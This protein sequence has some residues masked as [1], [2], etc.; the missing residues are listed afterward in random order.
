LFRE[1]AKIPILNDT[2]YL[3]RESLLTP[4]I[5]DRLAAF[6]FGQMQGIHPSPETMIRGLQFAPPWLLQVSTEAL[7]LSVRARKRLVAVEAE[8]VSDI[9]Q[10]GPDGLVKINGLGQKSLVD[11]AQAIFEAFEAGSSYC[12]KRKFERR[13]GVQNTSGKGLRISREPKEPTPGVAKAN[14][15]D[16]PKSF[17]ETLQTSFSLLDDRSASVL[18]Q[19]MGVGGSRKTLEEIASAYSLTRVRVRPLEAKAVKRIVS[20]MPLWTSRFQLGLEE[21][22]E[23]RPTPLPLV[24]LSVLDPWFIGSDKMQKYFG[25][26]LEHFIK[27]SDLNLLHIEGHAY[28][29]KLRQDEWE[30]AERSAKVLLA[31][32]SKQRSSP[33]E[34][35]VKVVID[36]QLNGRGEE[37]RP[38][39]WEI[40]TRQAYF[41]QGS[42]GD[43]VLVS[44]GAGAEAVVEAVLAESANPLHYSEIAK[45]CAKKGRAI[46]MRHVLNA[47]ANVGFLL[48]RGI[49]GLAKHIDFSQAEQDRILEE[50]E[51]MLSE[52][53]GRQWHAAEICDELEA[54]GLDFQGRLSEYHLNAIL[55][56][57]KVLA[58]LK[59]MVWAANT[60]DALGTSDRKNIWQAIV[61]LLRAHGSPMATSDIRECIS[62][63]RGLG[64]HF[65]IHQS[66]PLIRV[67]ENRWGILWRDV[68]IPESEAEDIVDELIS[69]LERR[70][71]GLH[72]TEIVPSLKGTNG[73]LSELDPILLVG[74][75]IRRQRVKTGHGGYIYLAEWG[76]SRRMTV[77]QAVEQAFDS[78]PCGV[79]VAAVAK[80]ASELLDRNVA[81]N[82]A[83]SVLME[84]GR[85]DPEQRLWLRSTEEEADEEL[86]SIA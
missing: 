84:I 19:R 31:S 75:A 62:R 69:L 50:V 44:F 2:H 17:L 11:I 4:E 5:R 83:T 34:R 81:T 10:I 73:S 43:R 21:M 24:G 9:S 6:R 49:Y 35:D 18:R 13:T 32:L 15:I 12:V 64:P 16:E 59:R 82:S 74:L 39:L 67:G 20:R 3:E 70:G 80:K 45:L 37:L 33:V 26:S 29:S 86:S 22:L 23:G 52:S 36:S 54:R 61:G 63:D 71:K 42:S 56:S 28:V 47:T 40:A 46:D 1:C 7:D 60:V 68:P 57:S 14:D 79:A 58:Y 51:D 48:G 30:E 8:T 38:L 77:S 41:S 27:G 25:Y 76:E 65:Q 85:Y 72:V 55:R 66:D 53:P 78:F